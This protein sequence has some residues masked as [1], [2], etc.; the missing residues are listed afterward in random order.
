MNK[1]VFI[2]GVGAG[3]LCVQV[4]V[5]NSYGGNNWEATVTG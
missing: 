1:F 2:S 5:L 4:S 3:L